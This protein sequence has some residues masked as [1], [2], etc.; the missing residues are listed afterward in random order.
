MKT[1]LLAL[2]REAV[3]RAARDDDVVALPVGQV[4]EDRLQRPAALVH[5]DDLVALAVPVEEVH[6]LGRAAELDLDVVVPHEQAAA[7]DRVA[8]GLDLVRAEVTRVRRAPIPRGRSARTRDLLHA[9]GRV[10]V[11]EDR[12]VPGEALEAHDLLGQK[13]PFSRN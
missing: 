2:G 10:E 5:E 13:R 12:L 3:G 9:A 8:A 6:R 4:A 11:V 7:A 1:P